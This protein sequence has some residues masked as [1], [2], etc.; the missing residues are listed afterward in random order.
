MLFG[1]KTGGGKNFG[2]WQG[3]R[4]LIT[5]TEFGLSS[6]L[7]F[8]Y[9]FPGYPKKDG[10]RWKY[11]VKDYFRA[12]PSGLNAYLD[13]GGMLSSSSRYSNARLS[14]DNAVRF[15]EEV[16]KAGYSTDPNYIQ[17]IKAIMADLAPIVENRESISKTWKIVM[18]MLISSGVVIAAYGIM[19]S[20]KKE[21]TKMK[22][23]GI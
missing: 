8:P 6:N 1:M 22:G 11:V 17:K 13:W 10:V 15:A 21:K 16:A 20:V 14:K 4:Q 9:I 3:D 23:L 12:Y 2:G 7:K 18:I 19:N 5:T